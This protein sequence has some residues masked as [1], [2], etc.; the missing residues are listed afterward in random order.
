[1]AIFLFVVFVCFYVVAFFR[2]SHAAG[3]PALPTDAEM[4]KAMRGQRATS[5]EIMDQAGARLRAYQAHPAPLRLPPAADRQAE[6]PLAVAQRFRTSDEALRAQQQKN[7]LLAFVSFSMPPASLKRLAREAALTGAVLVFRGLKDN[8]L[9]ATVTAF[10]P[11][12]QLGA[13]AQID[14]AAFERYHVTAVPHY[15]INAGDQPGCP[16]QA[17][18]CTRQAIELGGDVSLDYALERMS[19]SHHAL[20]DRADQFL[21]KLR[22]AP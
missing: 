14:P 18:V 10:K 16:T 21:S 19:A 5:D 17:A 2:L 15:V 9:K 7:D 22:P 13:K 6:D 12:A 1:L 11:Y 20:S 4:N 3:L 8:S